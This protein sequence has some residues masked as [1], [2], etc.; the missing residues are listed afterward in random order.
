MDNHEILRACKDMDHE[1]AKAFIHKQVELQRAE[2]HKGMNR[3]Q[4]MFA[5][6]FA[7]YLAGGL[8]MYS[9]AVSPG[10]GIWIAMTL[11]MLLP[12]CQLGPK[13][14]FLIMTKQY[15]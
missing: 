15:K 8:A 11:L 2:K 4:K 3:L 1:E 14:F 12:L 10:V 5:V 9:G 6:V 7:G 13:N